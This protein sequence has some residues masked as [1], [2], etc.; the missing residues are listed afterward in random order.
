MRASEP[1]AVMVLKRQ[2]PRQTEPVCVTA[3]REQEEN[4]DGLA[5]KSSET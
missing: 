5:Y 2:E 3:H 1:M 4:G